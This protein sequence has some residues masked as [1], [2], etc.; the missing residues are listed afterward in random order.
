MG[1]K[2]AEKIKSLFGKGKKINDD[3]YDE[4]TDLLVEGDIGAKTSY[5]IVEELETICSKEKIT[6]QNE[7]L[8]K[9]R[10]LLAEC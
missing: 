6:E 4:L 2:F 3:F 7:I 8:K 9:L 10:D 1:N 5:T